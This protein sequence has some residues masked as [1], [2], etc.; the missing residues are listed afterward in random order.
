MMSKVEEY[1]MKTHE[2]LNRKYKKKLEFKDTPWVY[3]IG[4]AN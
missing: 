4:E 2:L 3:E 1:D